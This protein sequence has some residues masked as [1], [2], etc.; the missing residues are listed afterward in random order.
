MEP[1]PAYSLPMSTRLFLDANGWKL[2]ASHPH[3][4]VP[5]APQPSGGGLAAAPHPPR[6]VLASCSEPLPR[7]RECLVHKRLAADHR[8]VREP[9][10]S[11]DGPPRNPHHVA[12]YLAL[13]SNIP[14]GLKSGSAVSL[15]PDSSISAVFFAPSPRDFFQN[16]C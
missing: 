15:S 2:V 13:H 4:Q 6:A 16:A 5:Q 9:E 11:G 1:R 7:V 3:S 14:A 10:R 12:K 8:A